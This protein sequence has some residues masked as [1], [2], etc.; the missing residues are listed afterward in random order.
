MRYL[1]LFGII[2]FLFACQNENKAKT[3]EAS[4]P[5]EVVRKWQGLMDKN[6]FAAAK[7]Y[8]TTNTI[9]VIESFESYF[10]EEDE[11]LIDTTILLNLKCVI[12]DNHSVCRYEFDEEGETYR[13]S[14]LLKRVDGKWLIDVEETDLLN[15][16]SL[17]DILENVHEAFE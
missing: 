5:E 6:A 9:R 13:D 14:F 7:K 11:S 3:K 8:S 16:E 17:E 1:Y 10:D 4:T 15:D 12:L 2:A